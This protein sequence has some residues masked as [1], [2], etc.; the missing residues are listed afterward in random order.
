MDIYTELYL[1][2][3]HIKIMNVLRSISLL[4]CNVVFVLHAAQGQSIMKQ[5]TDRK[6]EIPHRL[7]WYPGSDVWLKGELHLHSNHSTDASNNSVSKI[8]A[9]CKKLGMDFVAIT[10]HDNHVKGDVANHT[11]ADTAFFSDSDLILLYGAEWT[12]AKGHGNVFASKPYDHQKFYDSRE[13]RDIVIEKIKDS[14]GIHLSANHPAGKDHFGYSYDMVNSIEVWS[15]VIW[16][17]NERALMIWDDM[18]L[19]GKRLAARGGSDA[20]HGTPVGSESPV[21]NTVQAAYNYIGTPTNWVYSD[22][23][24]AESILRAL[25]QG[26]VSVSVN[27][28]AP[29]VEFYADQDRDG[30]MDA[31]MGDNLQSTGD[32]VRFTV[33]LSGTRNI[34]EGYTV[35]VFKNAKLLTTLSLD[36]QAEEISFLDAPSADGR[37]YYRVTVE[38][39]PIPYPEVPKSVDLTDRMI[40]LSNP[41]YFNFTE[42]I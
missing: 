36:A 28:Y 17:N 35:N 13:M 9:F 25:E 1:G 26:R 19:S 18:L 29:R 4:I 10:D 2:Y 34:G 14:L 22:D 39:E 42:D 12:T 40:A 5:T 23:K 6:E 33:K 7:M 30:K 8:K 31:M 38:G 37:S 16:K 11:W 27:P 21:E 3:L 20:H 24:T 32:S 15:T 41:I